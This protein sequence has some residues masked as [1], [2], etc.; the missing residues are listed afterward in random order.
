[1]YCMIL[2]HQQIRK[3]ERYYVEECFGNRKNKS[4]A[5]NKHQKN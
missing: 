2:I 5:I 4:G 3:R 1:M